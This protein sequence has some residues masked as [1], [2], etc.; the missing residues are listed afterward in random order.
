MLFGNLPLTGLMTSS[1]AVVMFILW[2]YVTAQVRRSGVAPQ[3]SVVFLNRYFLYMALFCTSMSVPYIWLDSPADFSLAMAIG[4]VVG[5]VFCYIAFMHISR[6][7]SSLIPSLVDKD[8]AIIMFWWVLISIVTTL[9]ALTMIW[10]TQPVFNAEQNLTIFNTHPAVGVM[11]GLMSVAA[12]VPALVLFTRGALRAKG[13]DK[14][15]PLLLAIGFA[16]VM[17]GGPMHDLAGNGVLYATADI[18]SAVSMIFIASGVVFR[19][20]HRLDETP[21]FRPVVHAPSNTL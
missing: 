5:H 2:I 15:K 21:S 8:R 11:I 16:V 1:V 3:R 13:T 17:V 14:I 20:E 18:L 12:I 6:M 4:Y 9:N 10:G 7:T 19:V